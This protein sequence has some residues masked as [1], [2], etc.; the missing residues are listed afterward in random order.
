MNPNESARSLQSAAAEGEGMAPVF[1][2]ILID[3]L[4]LPYNER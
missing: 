2:R 3:D 1:K 4:D